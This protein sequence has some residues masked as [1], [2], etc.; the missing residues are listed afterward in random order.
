MDEWLSDR[1]QGG[2]YDSQD[3]DYSLDDDGDYFTWS[4]DEAKGVLSG[5]ELEVAKLHYDI[6]E[7]GEMNHNH[8]KNVLHVT[9]SV[10]DIAKRLKKPPEQI[11]KVLDTAKKKMYTARLARPTPYVDKTVSVSWNGLCISAYL[12]AA[13]VLKL[14]SARKFALRSLDRVLSQG[15][16]DKSGLQHV[17]AYSDPQIAK[18]PQAAKIKIP[19]VLDDYAFTIIAC[20]HTYQPTPSLSYYHFPGYTPSTL[21]TPLH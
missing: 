10:G 14:D 5:E 3:A 21:I 6:G 18:A 13:Q 8:Q 19:G 15:W 4:L 2:F 17:I 1:E 16:S 11:R 20:L 7:V 9:T 12:K